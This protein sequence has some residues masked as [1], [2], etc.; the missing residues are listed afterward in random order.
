M[1]RQTFALLFFLAAGG[2]AIAQPASEQQP[3]HTEPKHEGCTADK[4]GD[5]ALVGKT[6]Q[7]AAALLKGCRWRVIERDG[8]SLPHT[9]DYWPDRR[10]LGIAKGRVIWVKRG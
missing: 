2:G 10:N 1:Y 4:L 3:G 8:E 6:E 9:M 5:Q 7:A